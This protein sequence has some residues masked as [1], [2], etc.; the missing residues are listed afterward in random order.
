MRSVTN[1]IRKGRYA[2]KMGSAFSTKRVIYGTHSL[3]YRSGIY[4]RS[5][6]ELRG[7]YF[8]SFKNH[9]EGVAGADWLQAEIY[10]GI[11]HDTRILTLRWHPPRPD[12]LRALATAE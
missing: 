9:D 4:C 10:V 1:N 8:V 12:L 7:H 3:P 5:N 2:E 6:S 11:S